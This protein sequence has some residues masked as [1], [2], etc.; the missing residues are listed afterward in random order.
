[1]FLKLPAKVLLAKL[2]IPKSV[3]LRALLRRV[4]WPEKAPKV[5]YLERP[6]LKGFLI[7]RGLHTQRFSNPEGSSYSKVYQEKGPH[8]QIAR[9]MLIPKVFPIKR[10][11]YWDLFTRKFSYKDVL[12][13]LG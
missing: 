8:T 2:L 12:K 6:I 4:F 3:L 11:P 13:V 9:K 5:S 1:M 7:Q 10:S